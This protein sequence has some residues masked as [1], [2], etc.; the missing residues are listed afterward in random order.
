MQRGENEVKVYLCLFTCT[1]TRAIYLEILQDLTAESFLLAF[2]KFAGRR[3][4]KRIMIS[5]NGSTYLSAAEDLRSLMKL[6]EVKEELG[7]RG[8]TWRFIP[9]R[10]GG[11]GNA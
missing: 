5:D 11:F 9:K 2:H 10:Y 8:V 1:T 4:L 7:R 6:P 3:S